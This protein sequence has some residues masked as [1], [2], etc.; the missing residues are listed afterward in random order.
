[1]QA[2]ESKSPYELDD[3]AIPYID[4]AGRRPASTAAPAKPAL[5][6]TGTSPSP[7]LPATSLP[8]RISVAPQPSM[9]KRTYARRR[10]SA[11]VAALLVVL[12]FLLIEGGG[13][14]YYLAKV[15]PTEL[16]AQATG[17]VQHILTAQVQASAEAKSQALAAFT[18]KSP[19]DI[20]N[21]ITNR[22]PDFSDPLSKPDGNSWVNFN[23]PGFS[24]FFKQGTYH[25]LDTSGPSY[26][27]CPALNSNFSNFAYQV[28]MSLLRGDSSE[29]LFRVDIKHNLYYRFT[30]YR[31]GEY[32]LY[33]N[34]TVTGEAVVAGG[35]NN[36]VIAALSSSSSTAT[37][38]AFD[39]YIYLYVNGQF[40]TKANDDTVGSGS[41]GVG[42]TS[43]GSLTETI[44]S[45]A[46]VWIL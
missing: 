21:Q 41:I 46:R 10:M 15:Q 42:P 17:V 9:E 33:A 19:Q 20:Y 43:D 36:A 44:F 40:L 24:C 5:S 16:N 34:H 1:M 35:S 6:P 37:I 18:A 28:Q 7:A 22:K 25:A 39:S 38:I 23:A 32:N 14:G 30:I 27:I 2:D 12:A 8:S 26:G 29:L 31:N 3:E 4:Y 11:G 13:F 45:K